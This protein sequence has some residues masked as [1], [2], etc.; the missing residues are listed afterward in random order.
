MS[1]DMSNKLPRSF[2]VISI[3]A[4]VWNLIGVM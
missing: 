3:A 1:E 4:L 2:Y